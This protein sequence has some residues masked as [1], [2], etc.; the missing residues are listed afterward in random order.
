MPDARPVNWAGNVVFSASE[1]RRPQTVAELQQLVSKSQRIRAL[2][3]RHSFSRIADNDGALVSVAGLTPV[4]EIDSARATVKVAAGVR[5]GDLAQYLHAAGY[6]LASL[7]SLPHICVAGACA[8]ATH[9][10]GDGTGNLATSVSAM[11]IVTADGDIVTLRRADGA[12]FGAAAVGLGA[13]GVVTSLYLDVLP[14]FDVRQQVYEGFTLNEVASHFEEIFASAYSVSVFTDWQSARHNQLWLK[15][16]T[17]DPCPADRGLPE[18]TARP[19]DGPRH[20]VPGMD[21]ASSTQQLG[22]PGPW[23]ERLP[24]FRLGFTPSSGEELQTEYL[25]PRHAAAEV[26]AA[27][28]GLAGRLG[29]VLQIGEIRTVAA[30]ELWLSPFYRR[31]AVCVHFTWANDPAGVLAVLGAVEDKLAPLGAR[32]HWGKLFT[33][34][35]ETLAGLYPRWQDFADC[36]ARHDPA[37]KFRNAFLDQYFL[38]Y[39][40]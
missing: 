11:D 5:Y 4:M 17:S 3:T 25:L 16:R 10:S 29:P 15:Q 28:A 35:R 13:F 19:A 36:M 23:H 31:D 33:I 12:G 32:P 2:G 38:P 40:R 24:H 26:L 6:A 1:I 34:P 20:P 27:M 7:G 39:L 8:T 37:G 30:D 9:G 18:L 22:V 14:T 21:P